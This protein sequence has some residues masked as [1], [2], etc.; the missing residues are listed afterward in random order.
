[1]PLGAL[2]GGSGVVHLASL[3]DTTGS[4]FAALIARDSNGGLLALASRRDP[5]LA[6]AEEARPYD[7]FLRDGIHP[8]RAAHA[9]VAQE[10]ARVAAANS[11]RGIP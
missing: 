5:C 9:L 4:P 2:H 6:F 7:C 1:M 8:T 3:G 11:S 10:D